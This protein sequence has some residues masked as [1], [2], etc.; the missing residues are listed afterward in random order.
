MLAMPITAPDNG[1]RGWKAAK[2]PLHTKY[3][4]TQLEEIESI[5]TGKN[6]VDLITISL[7]GNDLLLVQQAC[8]TAADVSAFINCVNSK[9][10]VILPAY[11]D[12]I[13]EL[14]SILRFGLHYTGRIV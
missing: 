5:L 8:S 1:C 12:H 7:G 10:E 11:G 14:L 4:S 6:S 13:S 3:D 2:W 9:L